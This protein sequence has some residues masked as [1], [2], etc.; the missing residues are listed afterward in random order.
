MIPLVLIP[1]M[2]CDARL[3]QPQIEALSGIYTIQLAP[4]TAHDT[5]AELAAEILENAPPKF[6][7]AGLSMGG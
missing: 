6:A 1:G 3:F 7:L 4:I 2:M 5:V